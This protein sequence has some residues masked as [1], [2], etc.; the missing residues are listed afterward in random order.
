VA[1]GE[2]ETSS[3]RSGVAFIEPGDHFANAVLAHDLKA[4]VRGG[5]L[6]FRVYGNQ[7]VTPESSCSAVIPRR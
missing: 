7:D 5:V 1:I 3:A 2:R 6:V 4:G